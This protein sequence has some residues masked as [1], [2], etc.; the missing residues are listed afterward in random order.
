MSDAQNKTSEE[1]ENKEVEIGISDEAISAIAN[2]IH[3]ENHDTLVTLLDPLTPADIARLLQTIGDSDTI[4]LV[5]HFGEDIPTDTFVYLNDDTAALVLKQLEPQHIGSIITDLDT[6][7]AVDL[8]E[9]FPKD[10]RKNILR[11]VSKRIRSLVEEGLT[12][13][14]D[15]AGRMMQR[16]FVAAPKFWTVGKTLDY[17]LG[18]NKDLPEGF[19]DIFIIDPMYHVI[20]EVP[21]AQ[22]LRAKRTTK[23]GDIKR[24]NLHLVP[25]TMDQE[26]VAHI[27]RRDTLIS[28][29][30]VD[31]NNR[32]LGVITID[33]IVDVVDEEAEEDIFRLAG[34]AD[35]DINRG[36]WRTTQSRFLWL[37]LNLITAIIASIAI[38]FFEA[39]LQE[40]V[41]LAV[42]M[43]IVASMGG[44]AGTQTLT[45]AVRALA[46]KELSTANAMRVTIKEVAVGCINGVA[47]ALI[48]GVVAYLW[49]D[50]P[51][52]GVTIAIAMVINLVVAGLAGMVIPLTLN[53]FKIDPALASAVLLTTITDIIGFGVFLGL[54]T[55]LLF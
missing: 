31:S 5:N 40:I 9:F 55:F 51:M 28:A 43:P 48:T 49:F 23:L 47:F 41:A 16:E 20:G 26:E 29:P 36:I 8:I 27:F 34:M 32:L 53:R 3:D 22:L 24:A 6:D 33:D 12:Y 13:P 10:E 42:L 4:A 50:N 21:L 18:L 17:L 39:T 44:N 7:D 37:I 19:H 2:A 52:I 46:T 54:A 1:Q 45:V 11:Y 30:V 38:G 14:E 25:A 35:S 15:S